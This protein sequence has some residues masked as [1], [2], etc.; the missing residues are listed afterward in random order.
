[1]EK[2]IRNMIIHAHILAFNEEKILPFTLDYY[3]NLCEK[4][5]IYDNMSTDGSDEIY[6]RYP[7]V[8]VIK[9]DSNNEINEMNYVNI[10]SNGY[11]KYSRDRQVKSRS[12]E[13]NARER[14][15]IDT[16]IISFIDSLQNP[17]RDSSRDRNKYNSSRG[18]S[19][20]SKIPGMILEIDLEMIESKIT[21]AK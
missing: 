7:K 15:R 21:H 6:T 3:S 12:R 17:I 9:W 19:P 18:Y 10:K 1:M 8:T 4:I 11:K 2:N 5:F 14:D 16:L 20:Q 13:S